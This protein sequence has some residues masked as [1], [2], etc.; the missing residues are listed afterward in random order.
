ML[1]FRA[2]CKGKYLDINCPLCEESEDTQAHMLHCSDL[3]TEGEIVKFLPEYQ[4]IFGTEFT[5]QI[6]VAR[7]LMDRYQKRKLKITTSKSGPSD[8]NLLWSAVLMY[9]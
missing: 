7:L 8:P 3:I 2:N 4:N 9:Y 1:E 5:K 6:E